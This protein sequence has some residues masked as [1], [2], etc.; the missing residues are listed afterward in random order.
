MFRTLIIYRF[1]N[2]IYILNPYLLLIIIIIPS[3]PS[4]LPL[5][6]GLKERLGPLSAENIWDYYLKGDDNEDNASIRASKPRLGKGSS[7]SQ[8]IDNR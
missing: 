6:K 3:P 1:Y 2:N 4:D 8:P 7:K 5:S